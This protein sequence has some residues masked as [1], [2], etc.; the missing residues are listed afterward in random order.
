M[1]N[2]VLLAVGL[3]GLLLT[4][5]AA[6]ENKLK[7]AVYDGK[8]WH[9]VTYEKG[10]GKPPPIASDSWKKPDTRIFVGIAQYRDAR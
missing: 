7:G 5:E 3:C 6:S 2:I 8:L 9:T 4:I 10:G 1:K